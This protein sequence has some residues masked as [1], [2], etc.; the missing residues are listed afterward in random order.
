M[1]RSAGVTISDHDLVFITLNLKNL[2][3]KPVYLIR[4]SYKHY[5]ASAF[6]SDISEAPW[7]VI[8]NCDDVDETEL[9]AFHLL[10]DPMLDQHAPVRR[11]R[12]RTRRNPFVT[13]EIKLLMK[14]RDNWRRQ[15]C[16]TNHPDAWLSYRNLKREV[17]QRLRNA[18][19]K[20]IAKQIKDNAND[21]N[22]LWKTIRSCIPNKGTI[23]K[24]F[25]KD[26]KVIANDFNT[27]FCSVGQKTVNEIH[28]LAEE[29]NYDLNRSPFVPRSFSP[30]YQFTFQVVSQEEVKQIILAMP[31]AKAPGSDKIHL[32]V[33]KDCLVHI[34][35]PL[36]SIIN[37][38]L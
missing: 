6:A 18:E 16:R 14:T 10:F 8:E 1:V 24:N 9:N 32:K 33:I 35:T 37:S 26:E 25:A 30:V 3:P 38:L 34:I 22:C 20:Y 7:S 4:R 11:V 28:S 15:A 19:R 31:S 27:F 12:L 17:K 23:S 5:D 13:D 36:T 21:S 29:F 2:R